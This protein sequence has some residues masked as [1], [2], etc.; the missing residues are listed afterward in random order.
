VRQLTT[1]SV[2]V[3]FL[4]WS[5]LTASETF[6]YSSDGFAFFSEAEHF[7]A[8]EEV[9]E[10]AALLTT[11]REDL[12]VGDIAKVYGPRYATAFQHT[13]ASMLTKQDPA[14]DERILV[15]TQAMLRRASGPGSS[16]RYMP[17]VDFDFRCGSRE[18]VAPWWTKSWARFILQNSSVSETLA[19]ELG[20]LHS[21]AVTAEALES[22]DES[23]ALVGIQTVWVALNHAPCDNNQL[24]LCS[25]AS[26]DQ[27]RDL[28]TYKIF[29]PGITAIGLHANDGQRWYAP[30]TLKFGQG[31]RFDA[32][33]AAHV[34]VHRQAVR[35]VPRLSVECRVLVLER[36][37]P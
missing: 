29:E 1:A 17:H 4:P 9:C 14:L 16:G 23:F 34:A 28:K 32:T 37:K 2:D 7:A 13:A 6:D 19:R 26:L 27:A 8:A 30:E 18:L 25:F 3:D 33:K 36:R 15:P 11:S 22:F 12:K 20:A 21:G 5:T 24:A 31:V 35:S 10:F